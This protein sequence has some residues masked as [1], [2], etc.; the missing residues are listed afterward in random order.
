[1]ASLAT[2]MATSIAFVVM[3]TTHRIKKLPPE[4]AITPI[5]V[6]FGVQWRWCKRFFGAQEPLDT[7]KNSSK[8]PAFVPRAASA[9]NSPVLWPAV[10]LAALRGQHTAIL[11]SSYQNSRDQR[12]TVRYQI[13]SKQKI[14]HYFMHMRAKTNMGILDLFPSE[15]SRTRGVSGCP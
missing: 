10:Q 6:S 11:P 8:S 12:G 3:K 1:M 14:F 5:S 2:S 15:F 7:R 9:F 4:N 13:L